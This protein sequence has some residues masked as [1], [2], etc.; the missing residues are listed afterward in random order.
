MM[1]VTGYQGAVEPKDV[2]E[3]RGVSRPAA[4]AY[5]SGWHALYLSRG[6]LITF[7]DQDPETA[8]RYLQR[9]ADQALALIAEIGTAAAAAAE[10]RNADA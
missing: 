8:T 3:V 5:G 4:N 2:D 1:Q 7:D 9:V 10:V 6:L